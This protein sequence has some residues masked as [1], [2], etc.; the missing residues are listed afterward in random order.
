[1]EAVQPNTK[2]VMRL[3]DANTANEPSC[4]FFKKLPTMFVLIYLFTSQIFC[5]SNDIMQ[6]FTYN[7]KN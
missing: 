6:R 5:I 1:M 3:L 2:Q 7:E 4:F